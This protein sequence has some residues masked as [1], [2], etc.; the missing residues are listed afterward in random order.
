[1]TTAAA[2]EHCMAAG[3]GGGMKEVCYLREERKT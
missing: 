3:V 2:A 1:V